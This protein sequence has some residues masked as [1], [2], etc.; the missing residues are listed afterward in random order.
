MKAVK[1][2]LLGMV[3]L[4]SVVGLVGCAKEKVG[5]GS[6]PSFKGDVEVSVTVRGNKV[7][8]ASVVSCN[9]TETIGAAAANQIVQQAVSTGSVEGLDVVSGATISSNAVIAALNSAVAAA[10]GQATIVA[11]SGYGDTS[12]DI[13]VI[14]A[15]G[16]GLSAATEAAMKG[17]KVIVL[18]KMGIVGGNTNYATGGLNASETSIQKNLGINDSNQA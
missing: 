15:G 3:L 9:D 7:I 10:K 8:A 2:A 13:V 18:E 5:T 6:A 17:K 12:C 16:A 14:G 1:K 4:V 11:K